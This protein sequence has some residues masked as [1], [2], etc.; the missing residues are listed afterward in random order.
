MS[1]N[2]IPRRAL[3][4]LTTAALVSILLVLSQE[5]GTWSRALA[6][7]DNTP[8]FT[9][10][11]LAK[12]IHPDAQAFGLIIE[13]IRQT[14]PNSQFF[15]RSPEGKA[16][17][18]ALGVKTIFYQ[19]DRNAWNA[20][21]DDFTAEPLTYPSVLSPLEA[22]GIAKEVGAEFVPLLNVTVLC[23]RANPLLPYSSPNVDCE[24]VKAKDSVAFLKFLRD[25]GVSVKHVVLGLEPYE[26]C[27]WWFLG[28]N[29]TM[30][31]SAPG[32]HRIGLRAEDYV[33]RIN[34]WATAIHT[35]VDKTIKIGAHIASNVWD[36]C[37]KLPC[38]HSWTQTVLQQ[39]G[40]NID[41]ALMHQYFRIPDPVAQ[42]VN[43]AV[44]YSYYQF[45]KDSNVGNYGRTGMPSEMRRQILQWAPGNKKQMPLWYS[46]FNSSIEDTE[47]DISLVETRNS[48]YGGIALGELYLDLLSPTVGNYPG[49]AR[50]SFHHLFATSTFL[51]AYQPPD[52]QSQT[53]VMTPGWYILYSLQSFAN[54]NWLGVKSSNVPKNFTGRASI[55]VYAAR[56]G[57]QVTVAL[58][59]HEA[60]QALTVDLKLTNMKAKTVSVTQI[61]DT[62]ASILASNNA[63]DPSA[64]TPHTSTLNASQI[65]GSG[66]DNL[67]L[68]AHSVTVLH[69]TLH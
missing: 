67:S 43:T 51:G 11:A 1:M 42:D 29:C 60:T 32:Q 35:K 41:F 22:A 49:A 58:F 19:I 40:A 45:Q 20:P 66:L 9:L 50:A 62:A 54:K 8:T 7:A 57:K 38:A 61:G 63:A 10:S 5:N 52:A 3:R 37:V 48:L 65:M 59:N 25:H 55:K 2:I 27:Q 30:K 33:K 46:E 16:A 28:L 6:A 17:L 68:P 13:P 24:F 21:Y 53:M 26:G 23:K 18:K 36:Y 34:D 4:G 14:T 47:D 56:K 64:I 15:Y 69:I 39:A 12:S 31:K 44:K